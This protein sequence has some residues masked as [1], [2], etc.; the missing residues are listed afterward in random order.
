MLVVVPEACN[1]SAG[2]ISATELHVTA[3]TCVDVEVVVDRLQRCVRLAGS[4]G[5]YS[6]PPSQEYA[7]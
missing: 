1:E 6:R 5:I 3:M 7:R 4:F 2:S